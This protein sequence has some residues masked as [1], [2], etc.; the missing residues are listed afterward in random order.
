MRKD[1]NEKSFN[2]EADKLVRAAFELW[3][4][5]AKRLSEELAA[6]QTRQEAVRKQLQQGARR[7]DGR[8]LRR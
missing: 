4:R 6:S 5:E 7:T 1:S 3:K 2:E 8:I